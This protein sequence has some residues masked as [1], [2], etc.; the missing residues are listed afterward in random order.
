M[1][2]FAIIYVLYSLTAQQVFDIVAALR[3]KEAEQVTRQLID[4]M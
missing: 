1:T 4:G 2:V 3:S